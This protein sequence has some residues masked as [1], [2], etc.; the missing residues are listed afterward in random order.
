MISS[1]VRVWPSTSPDAS[2]LMR[3]FR[4]SRRRAATSGAKYARQLLRACEPH[5]G[6]EHQAQHLDRPAVEIREVLFG[7]AEHLGDHIHREM[8]RE[9]SHQIGASEILHTLEMIVH[10]RCD[11]IALPV[12]HRPTT[13][14]LLHD[15]SIRAVLGTPIPRITRPRT[16]PMTSLKTRWRI[17]L[18]RGALR[19]RR[20]I[21]ER[22]TQA[23]RQRSTFRPPRQ[24]RLHH[25]RVLR[26]FAAA[27][28]STVGI[29]DGARPV[30]TIEDLK[31]VRGLT[32]TF[33]VHG[34]TDS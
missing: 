8:K 4:G 18:R 28:P 26:L 22:C 13:E 10:D 7:E 19:P 17:V 21:P 12:R 1:S 9:I 6:I 23:G 30:P 3:S 14:R 33:L 11:D 29:A 15:S 31:G 27:R 2:V 34:H 16:G 24:R 32:H 25:L 20:R 5:L